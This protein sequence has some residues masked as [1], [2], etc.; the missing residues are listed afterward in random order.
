MEHYPN[1]IHALCMWHLM[2]RGDFAKIITTLLSVKGQVY[3]KV[4]TAWMKSWMRRL[5]LKA[6]FEH[7]K[8]LLF[9][10]WLQSD[11]V[12][13]KESLTEKIVTDI[14]NFY[15]SKLGPHIRRWARFEVLDVRTLNVVATS[16]VEGENS[17][18]D[19]VDQGPKP[20]D[21]LSKSA[22]A[23]NAVNERRNKKKRQ[24]SAAALDESPTSP[25]MQRLGRT[26]VDDCVKKAEEEY[27]DAFKFAAFRVT[28]RKFYIRQTHFKKYCT[29]CKLENV[30]DFINY[31]VPR[32]DVTQILTIQE[33]QVSG[34][35]F[36][37]INAVMNN[38][39][40]LFDCIVASCC[41]RVGCILSVHAAISSKLDDRAL[42]YGRYF[43]GNHSR[44]TSYH[45]TTSGWS[46]AMLTP[47]FQYGN[48]RK[49]R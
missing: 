21:T 34:P 44:E 32:Y 17:V 45:D 12:Q 47:T 36:L 18:L 38:S 11:E 1:A 6:Q 4:V 49:I 25:M 42:V 46:T 39:D 3:F 26:L 48:H 41:H 9:D 19:R 43:G 10:V 2:H 24:M 23:I 30:D 14:G 37:H 20:K 22:K 5:Q 29:D 28:E 16:F 15:T 7:S 40:S 13:N 31:M 8:S 33:F 27:N 35:K